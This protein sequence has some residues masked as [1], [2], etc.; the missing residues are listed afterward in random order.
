M[1]H[2]NDYPPASSRRCRGPEGLGAKAASA[3]EQNQRDGKGLG[4]VEEE[5]FLKGWLA[6]QDCLIP[7]SEFAS[8][9]PISANTSEHVVCYRA[10]DKRVVKKTWPGTF[11]W[12]PR[13]KEGVWSP[14]QASPSEYLHRM[15]LQNDLFGDQIILEGGIISDGPSMIIGQPA[16]GL[17]LVI[18]QPFLQ[19]ANP[20]SPHP[21]EEALTPYL[22]G[23]GFQRLL[24]SFFGWINEDQQLVVL[25]AK[26]DNFI[27]TPEGILPIDLLITEYELAA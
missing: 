13:S 15:A 26:P 16:G 22:Q 7:D 2:E 23:Y 1:N 14:C 21:T 6:D 24:N 5:L 8:L 3:L 11:G 4:A 18:S 19:P 17:S 9:E 10:F 27:L 12:I 20:S 25:D